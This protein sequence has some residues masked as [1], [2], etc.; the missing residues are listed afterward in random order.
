MD[1]GWVVVRLQRLWRRAGCELFFV[2]SLAEAVEL[3]AV[4][5]Q[6]GHCDLSIM[7]LHGIQRGQETDFTAHQLEPVL[8]DLEQISRWQLYASK[9]GKTLPGIV[10]F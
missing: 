1:T 10:A 3:R 4:F 8:N 5:R 7:V 2:A 9:T 6:T